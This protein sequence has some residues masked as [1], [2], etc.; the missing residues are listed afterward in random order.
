MPESQVL[1]EIEVDQEQMER[2]LDKAYRKL[3]QR[4]DVP[5]FRK[6]KTPRAMLERH[7]GRGR[8]VREAVDILIPEA[9]NKALDEQ[10]IDP[11]DQPDIELIADEPLA[12]KATVPVR[13]TLD[14]GDYRSLRVP[15]EPVALD[16]KDVDGAVEE[17]RRRYAIHEPADRPVQAGDLVTANVR[18]VIEDHEV[19]KDDDAQLNLREGATVLLPGFAEGLVGAEKGASREV[20]VTVP[21]GEQPLSGKTG[22][23]YVEV[24]EVKQ[25]RLPDLNDDFAR[26]VGEGFASV[27]ALRDRLRDDLRERME[28]QAEDTYRDGAVAALV[29]NA[30]TIEFPPVLV[31]RE[32]DRL[33]REE[34]R[35]A[36][37][38]VDSY[39]ELIKK[40]A[41]QF[42]EELNAAATERVKRSLALTALAEAEEITVD[43]AE[44]D[45]EIERIVSSSG[46]QADQLR[47]LFAGP[48]ARASMERSLLTRKTLD[49]LAEVVAQGGTGQ[50][51]TTKTKGAPEKRKARTEAKS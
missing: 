50:K 19:F 51:A 26:G 47:R 1:L 12:F 38:D 49:R 31:E 24:K 14:I 15:R 9:Y 34:A 7:L 8:L 16:E 42:R 11:I 22:T 2:S 18:I 37:R 44:V 23:A 28:A 3:V 39:L 45:A 27:A 17:L 33:L 10:E 41:S 25:E 40:D 48:D 20:A 29:E 5:G 36:G 43:G 4:V 30:K 32:I 21:P 35:A 13:P 6:G 46:Q